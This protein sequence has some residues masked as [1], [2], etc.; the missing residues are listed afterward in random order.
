M[1]HS[2]ISMSDGFRNLTTCNDRCSRQKDQNNTLCKFAPWKKR[3]LWRSAQ[4]KLTHRCINTSIQC[5]NATKLRNQS[6]N[7]TKTDPGP[8]NITISSCIHDTVI[9]ENL[10]PTLPQH[11]CKVAC[12]NCVADSDFPDA[13]HFVRKNV[14]QTCLIKGD[15]HHK[16]PPQQNHLRALQ[17]TI[18]SVRVISSDY[19]FAAS[20]SSIGSAID[21]NA[22]KIFRKCP[23]SAPKFHFPTICNVTLGS[24]RPNQT[25]LSPD[26]ASWL[27]TQCNFWLHRHNWIRIHVLK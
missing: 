16:S 21:A 8:F 7:T 20:Q 19:A 3:G 5:I 25:P 1:Y 23:T 26:L 2:Q 4:I 10:G 12:G 6:D 27:K 22:P 14:Q 9:I 15:P 17:L 18:R 11:V 13:G 24:H